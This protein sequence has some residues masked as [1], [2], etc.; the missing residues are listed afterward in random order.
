MF[1]KFASALTAAV[2]VVAVAA[3]AAPVLAQGTEEE[4]RSVSQVIRDGLRA[5]ISLDF[6]DYLNRTLNRGDASATTRTS[7]PVRSSATER[8]TPAPTERPT[9]TAPTVPGNAS[10]GT[11]VALGDSVAAGVGLDNPVPVPT[12]ETRCDRTTEAYAYDVAASQNL[13]LVFL[14]CSGATAGDLITT[15]RSGSPNQPAQLDRAFA[16]GTP[17]LITIT[18]GAND[19]RWDRFLATCR[20]YNCATETQ[21]RLSDA[22]LLTLRGKLHYVFTAIHSRSSANTPTVVITGYYNPVSEACVN[23]YPGITSDEISAISNRV[24]ELN[25]TIQEVASAYSFVRF[26]PVDFSGHDICSTDPWV[27]GPSDPDPIHPTAEGQDVIARS[28][29]RT[30]N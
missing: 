21:Q 13:P 20:Y 12:R 18:A 4:R 5:G 25:R 22:R 26:A 19:V 23:T 24:S 30:L 17:E 16:A 7:E 9:T 27:Q 1:K 3:P 28:I 6:S 15:Q 8:A 2:L 14:A 10:S 29:I 11:Y